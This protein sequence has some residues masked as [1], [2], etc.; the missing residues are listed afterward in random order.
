MD[1][2]QNNITT[3]HTPIWIPQSSQKVHDNACGLNT[4]VD[5]STDFFQL[6]NNLLQRSEENSQ[7]LFEQAKLTLQNIQNTYNKLHYPR[8]ILLAAHFALCATLDDVIFNY[9]PYTEKKFSL[10]QTFHQDTAY[11]QKFFSL[12]N[13]AL[14]KINKYIDLIELLYL[15]MLF[16]FKGQFKNSEFGFTQY[17]Q[18][19]EKVYSA[20][21][22]AR[23]EHS[24]TISPALITEESINYH[25]MKKIAT[26]NAKT[27]DDQC[28]DQSLHRY[29][30]RK[31]NNNTIYSTDITWRNYLSV[32]F[33]TAL[34]ILMLC[35][36]FHFIYENATSNTQTTLTENTHQ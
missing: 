35:T 10:L 7:S 36:V 32:G 28:A 8:D 31:A 34:V 3:K 26:N 18:L 9:L 20:I 4:L 22:Y 24:R 11:E 23:G 25:H 5:H 29:L 1:N 17:Q 30:H 12:L 27:Q 19:S 21:L 33:A 16:G 15:C 14:G 13:Y 2:V 6:L